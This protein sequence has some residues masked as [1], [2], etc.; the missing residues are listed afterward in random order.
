M[1][2]AAAGQC[3]RRA[4]GIQHHGG[5]AV[6][7]DVPLEL[8]IQRNSKRERQV[9]EEVMRQ[10]AAKLKPAT[11]KEGFSKIVVVRVKDSAESSAV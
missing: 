4:V 6:F 10:K 1:A 8:C 9:Q 3:R 5:T 7:F 11:F 2:L